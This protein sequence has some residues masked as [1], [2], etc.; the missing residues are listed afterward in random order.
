MSFSEADAKRFHRRARF[1]FTQWKSP[2]NANLFHDVDAILLL[3]GEDDYENPY[4]K[5]VTAETWLLGVPMYQTLILLTPDKTTFVCSGKK[6][7]MLEGLKKGDKQVT[8]DV[9]RRTKDAEENMALYKPLIEELSGKR[10]G[11]VEKDKFTGKNIDEWKKA[12]ESAG[13]SFESVD[14]TAALSACLA[15]KDEDEVKTMR[16]ASRLSVN[17]MKNYFIDE[18]STIV[19]EERTVTHEKLSEQTEAILDDPKLVKKLRLPPEADNK[20]DVDW[21]YS[22][23]VQSGG[24]YDLKSSAMSNSSNL[25]SGVIMCSLGIRYKYYCSNIGRTFLI[26]PNKTQEKNYEFL[27]ELQKKIMSTIKDGVKI[28]DVYQQAQEYIK[29]KRPDLEKNFTRSIGFGM[30]I[31]FREAS[32]VLHAKNVRELRN[33]M[34]LNLSVGFAD[35]ENPKPADKRS[36]MY[37]L[38]LIDTIR[39][40]NDAPVV[41]TDGCSK[42]LNE[43]SYFFKA[44]GSESDAQEKR[45]IKPAKKDTPAKSAILRSKFRSEDQD[46]ESRE[47]RRKEHQKQLFAKKLAEG[48]AKFSDVSGNGQDENKPVFKKF[49][50]YRAESKLPQVKEQK[51]IVDKRNETIILPFYGMAVP[52]HITTLKNASKSDEGDFVMLRLNFITPG[53]AGGKKEDMPFHDANATFVRALTFRSA[54]THRM[55]QIFREITDLKKDAAKKEA[56][57]KEMADVVEQDNLIIVKGR[58][59][60]RLPDVYVRPQLDGK[61]LPG[62]LEIHTNGIRY[63]SIKSDQSF[64]VL[65]SNVKHLFFQPCD[66]ELLVLI[67]IHFKNPVVIG[68]KKTKDIQF[69]RE[70][71]DIQFDETGNKRRRHMYGDEDELE[72]EQE[73]RRRRANLNREFK[74]FAEKIAE[75]SDGRVEVDTPFRELGFTGVPFRSN[76]LLQPTTDCLVHLSDPPFL[77]VTISEI[78]IAHLERV[79]FGLKNFDMVFVF[80]D[81]HRAPIQ[82]NTIPMSQLDNVKDWLDSVEVAFT[83]GPVNLN[84]SMILKT[85]LNDPADFYRNGGW[86][87]LG[88]GSDEEGSE[89][90]SESGSEFEM[91]EDD[92]EESASDDESDFASEASEDSMDE[93]ELSDSGDDWDELEEKARKADERKLKRNGEEQAPPPAARKKQKRH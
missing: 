9:L 8:I 80:K 32:Y 84:W 61:R 62:E 42:N 18:M 40:T 72:S 15:V 11:V 49:E 43:V 24:E 23:I 53:Q 25:H 60:Y 82:I 64:N 52:F 48:L 88:S 33:G 65:F 3:I 69:Y 78:E 31:E 89:Q 39:V 70:A 7:D 1:L 47:Q 58:R 37:S 28:R 17:V 51:I 71:S 74:T 93:E 86:N 68:K 66:N 14:I 63:Q 10:V 44:E 20:E 57:R 16:I 67:H 59:P 27:L 29:A 45:P 13:K 21:C 22:P 46:E 4:R 6:A 30:G 91:S 41:L 77:I 35:L 81:L 54:D 85:V 83:E 38:L 2:S 12:L 55:A 79:Q 76:V 26:D 75:A 73:E 87:F 34:V 90:E 92:F 36:K 50:S 19:D 56:Q 5:S